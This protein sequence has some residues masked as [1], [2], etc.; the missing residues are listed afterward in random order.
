MLR[1]CLAQ[2]SPKFAS[3]STPSLLHTSAVLNAAKTQKLTSKAKAEI[4][5]EKWRRINAN[6]PSPVF[7][8]R[9]GEEYKWDN[10]H[11]AKILVN[12]AELATPPQMTSVELPIGTVNLPPQMGFGVTDTDAEKLFRQLPVLS[13]HTKGSG[14]DILGETVEVWGERVLA[15]ENL[16][17]NTFAKVLDLRNANADGIAYE[18]KRRIIV[19]FSTPENPFD[20]G[21]TEVQ[22]AILTYRIRNLGQHLAKFP[23]D[24]GNRLGLRKLVHHRAKI[25]RY[26]RR[27]SNER[28]ETLLEQLGLERE[29]V[30]GELIV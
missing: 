26:L 27:K 15:R 19:A 18:N 1:A 14:K 2:N 21:R 5:A 11:L 30:E 29:S 16:K 20:P 10:C 25:L 12:E 22:A 28:Y 8:T 4:K 24:L 6:R 23:R 7:G 13:M 17:A 3:P 9:K